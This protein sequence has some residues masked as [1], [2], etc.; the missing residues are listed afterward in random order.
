MRKAKTIKAA[1]KRFSFTAG[2]KIK[3]RK[4]SKSHLL[5]GKRKKRKRDLRQPATVDKADYR[6]IS[7]MLPYG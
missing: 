1:A 3:R 4:A 7:R 6:K 5:T 2:G